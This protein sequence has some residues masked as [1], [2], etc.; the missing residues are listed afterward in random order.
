MRKKSSSSS[1]TATGRKSTGRTS[2]SVDN[3]KMKKRMSWNHHPNVTNT[4]HKK[5]K[6]NHRQPVAESEEETFLDSEDL[7]EDFE[8][9]KKLLEKDPTQR[10]T[11]T[12]YKHSPQRRDLKYLFWLMNS[13]YSI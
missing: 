9:F 13:G 3:G 2:W 1:T 4:P 8:S 11:T 5:L 7:C 6:K 12:L 10:K